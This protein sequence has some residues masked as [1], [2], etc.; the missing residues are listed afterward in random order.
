MI[1]L[2]YIDIEEF[3]MRSIEQKSL[4][5][6]PGFIAVFTII[7]LL[8]PGCD[9]FIDDNGGKLTGTVIIVPGANLPAKLQWLKVNS[10]SNRQYIIEVNQ[11]ETIAPYDMFYADKTGI[12]IT[13]RGIGTEREISLTQNGTL[14]T[15]GQGVTLILENMITLSGGEITGNDSAY[16][17][18][19]HLRGTFYLNGGVIAK[20]CANTGGGIYAYNSKII[21]SDTGGIIY[22]SNGGENANT[23]TTSQAIHTAFNAIHSSYDNTIG[24]NQALNLQP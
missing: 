4:I 7:A 1:F 6:M 15:V 12:Q 20:N 13:I 11:N 16:G 17:G 21:K 9:L 18:G 10:A 14:F 3:F 23:A 22:G 8:I 5:I 19:V 2:H 24:E